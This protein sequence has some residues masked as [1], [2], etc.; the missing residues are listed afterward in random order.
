VVADTGNAILLNSAGAPGRNLRID[1]TAYECLPHQPFGGATT[2][3]WKAGKAAGVPNCG[4]DVLH[5]VGD[6]RRHHP[7]LVACGPTVEVVGPVDTPVVHGRQI[8]TGQFEQ[9]AIW[10][11]TD[12]NVEYADYRLMRGSRG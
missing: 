3:A 5:F 6:S 7:C 2:G 11:E 10:A 8:A 9:G 1:A 4:P 12:D